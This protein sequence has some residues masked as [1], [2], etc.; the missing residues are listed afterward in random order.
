MLHSSGS[1]TF[2]VPK[3][4]CDC[5]VHVFGP[6]ERFPLAV[7]R[8]Y[9][10]QP[11]LITEL[12]ARMDTAGVDRAIIV[13]PSAYGADNRCTLEATRAH[14]QRLRTVAV[15]DGSESD[16]VLQSMH[17]SGARGIRVNIVSGGGPSAADFAESLQRGLA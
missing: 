6:F 13:Q 16:D 10:P 15:I 4:A 14:P 2:A 1:A 11:A 7:R 17:E 5:H 9:T 8:S 12:L 3:G